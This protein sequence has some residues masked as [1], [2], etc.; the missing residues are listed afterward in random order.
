MPTERVIIQFRADGSRKVVRGMNDIGKSASNAS[1]AAQTLRRAL[2]FVGV[3]AAIRSS[4]RTL[5][6]FEQSISTVRAIS[7]ATGQTLADL[8]NEAQR[9]GATTRFSASQASEGLIFLSRAGFTAEQSLESLEGT[10]QLAQAGGLDLGSAADIA[11]N[12]L[13]GFRLDVAET[14]RVVDV[15]AKAANSSNTD[16]RQLGDA[17]KFAAPAAAAVGV[18]IEEAA[19]AVGALSNAGLQATLAGTGLRQSLVKLAAPSSKAQKTLAA[20]GLSAEDVNVES[21][22]L[23]TAFQRLGDAGLTLSD[24][25]NIFDVRTAS[26]ALVLADAARS[27]NEAGDSFGALQEKLEQANGTAAEVARVM[28]DNLNGAILAV[29]SATEAVVLALGELGTTDFLTRA[30]RGL[31]D[32]LRLAADNAGNLAQGI[33][34]ALL[35]ALAGLTVALNLNPIGILIT[36]LG[37]AIALLTTFRDEIALSE[38][39]LVSLGDVVDVFAENIQTSV[40]V[41]GGALSD[42]FGPFV[43][44]ATNDF[45]EV[46]SSFFGF[47]RTIARGADFITRPFQVA[48]TAIASFFQF[49]FQAIGEA[50]V[51]LVNAVIRAFNGLALRIQRFINAAL[52]QLQVLATQG[53]G[54]LDRVFGGDGVID[55]GAGTV[56]LPQ[57]GEF[58]NQLEGSGQTLGDA[59]KRGFELSTTGPGGFEQILNGIINQST[60]AA[61]ERTAGERNR[62]LL[63]G[64]TVAELGS[65]LRPDAGTPGGVPGG[66]ADETNNGNAALEARAAILNRLGDIQ[67]TNAAAEEARIANTEILNELRAEGLVTE[68][69]FAQLLEEFP[70]NIMETTTAFESL[71]GAFKNIDTSAQA[72]G[73]SIGNALVGAIG[74]ASGALADF[75]VDGLQ[76]VDSLKEAFAD[77]LKNLAKQILQVIIQTLILRAIQAG[78]GGGGGGAQAG[79][80]VGGLQGF[81]AGGV[82]PVR[83]PVLVGE[84]GPEIFVPTSSGNVVPNSQIGKPEVNVQVVN[85]RDP[86]EVPEALDT[87][88]AQEKIINTVRNNRRA[89]DN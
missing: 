22:G 88:E 28:D 7:G 71:A 3:G 89:I 40:D 55:L 82:P 54:V 49:G 24:A 42:V 51:D 27:S 29:K 8:R 36:A 39:G 43:E 81:Q 75:I 12:V 31:A 37:A 25:V 15:L 61:E 10:L 35:P 5:A 60:L 85:V 66:S 11:S 83:E 38:D 52:E 63:N 70:N 44:G 57:F 34:V 58:E 65:A 20:L 48:V 80:P 2:L 23:Q 17:L 14:G 47:L 32:L 64:G 16:V 84:Q 56:A 79:G 69:E 33:L 18:P 86:N 68:Q 45:G 67:K 87:P 59:L 77:L 76:D 13:K 4:I 50:L 30:L 73:A 6:Q 26:A 19:A 1:N 74:Q 41:I 9:L 21:V 62:L 46:E 53:A 78:L 72:L